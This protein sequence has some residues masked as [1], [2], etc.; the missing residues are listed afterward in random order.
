MNRVR[1]LAFVLALLV[2]GAPRVSLAAD[3][4]KITAVVLEVK[5]RPSANAQWARAKVGT[6][7]PAGSQV[8]TGKRSKCE[9]RFPDGSLVRLAPQTDMVISKIAGKDMSLGHGKLY[10][11]IVSGTNAKIQGGTGVASIKGTTLEFDAGDIEAPKERR[12]SALTIFEGLAELSGPNGRQ[13]V[14]AGTR[15]EV[16]GSGT[17]GGLTQTPGASFAGGTPGQ[18]WD[19]VQRGLNVASTPGSSAGF[20]QKNETPFGG[21][22]QTVVDPPG[23]YGLQNGSLV[24]DVRSAS[25]RR[26]AHLVGSSQYSRGPAMVSLLTPPSA[27]LEVA[28]VPLA[29][30]AP[31]PSAFGKR[32]FG[33]NF[34]VDT[35]AL[36]GEDSLAGL[37]VRPTAVWNDLYF[38][39]GATGFTRF[40]DGWHTMLTEALVTARPG[41]GDVTVGRQHFLAG[42]VNN[43]NLGSLIGF[44][45]ADAARWQPRLGPVQL[46]LAYV[47]DFLPF[48]NDDQRG[49]YGRAQAGYWGGT[50]GLNTV[51]FNGVGTGVTFDFSVPVIAGK[52]DVYGEFG[53]DPVGNHLETWGSYFPDLYQRYD[54]DLF[55]EYAH[56]SNTD[57]LYSLYAYKDL[58]REWTGVLSVLHSDEDD[59]SVSLGA[60]KRF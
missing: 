31:I 12:E 24:I 57:S 23:N 50:F 6:V 52:W 60:I 9:I 4:A 13:M 14:G 41:C 18:W 17:P 43:S 27:L 30:Q 44:D 10:A 47:D 34:L 42:P 37:R 20:D 51:H 1:P 45:T 5:V 38:E 3:A 11:R 2:L 28:P 40:E 15:S 56:R 36:W 7:L 49:T 29:Q 33:P 55:V 26:A 58:P 22:R 19:G 48:K 46:D 35:F 59:L 21:S 32:F 53:D 16:G 54:L 25:A 39:V 8:R